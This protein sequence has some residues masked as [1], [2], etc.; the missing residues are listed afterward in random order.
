M[1]A[2]YDGKAK[3]CYMDTDSFTVYIKA[4]DI[5]KDIMKDVEARFDTS[6]HESDRPLLKE[7][8]N[9][10]LNE[11]QVWKNNERIGIAGLRAKIYSY[12]IDDSSEDKKVK[13]TKKCVI[14]GTLKFEYYKIFLGTTQLENKIKHEEKNKIDVDSLKEDHKE[15]IKTIN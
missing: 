7:Q 13:G 11:R 12:L 2:K 3:L 4:D 6:K 14:K 1:K 5:Y 8:K 10:Q 9:Y 15:F